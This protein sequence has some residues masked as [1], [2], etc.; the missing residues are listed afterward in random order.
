M[1]FQTINLLPSGI[2]V[3]TGSGIV[4]FTEANVALPQGPQGMSLAIVHYVL[5]NKPAPLALR[6][7]LDKKAFL[8]DLGYKEVGL[9]APRVT[10][11]LGAHLFT[12][13]R[14]SNRS[15]S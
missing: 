7:D 12:D 10:A 3:P 4:K 14:D 15:N 5:D 2:S 8:D 11:F 9:A 6:L 13:T 1:E